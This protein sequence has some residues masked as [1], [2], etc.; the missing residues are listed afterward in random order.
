M[1]RHPRF[2][3]HR[4]L[5]DKRSFIYYDCDDPDEF[6]EVEKI[7]IEKIASFAPD[8]EPEA[9]NRGFRRAKVRS[10]TGAESAPV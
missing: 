5:G 6:A 8:I 1:P 3:E 7:P 2:E 4:Y 9:R 10:D